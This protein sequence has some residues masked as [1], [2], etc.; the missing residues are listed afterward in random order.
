MT[1]GRGT[2]GG[3]NS[4]FRRRRV[5]HIVLVPGSRPP[6]RARRER[7][8][9]LFG[10]ELH[11]IKLGFENI[12]H[13][14]DRAG[15][16]QGEYPAVHV[17]GTNG[18][19]SVLAFLDA[20]LRAAGYRVGRYTSPHL[21]RLNERFLVDGGMI[22]DEALDEQIAFFKGIADGM[23]N[24]P[25]FFEMT[26]AIAFRHFAE[27]RVDLALVE[28]GLG[29][30]LDSTNVITPEVT[31]INTIGLEHTR[32]LGDTLEQ[33]AYEKAG[34]LKPGVPAVVGAIEEGPRAVILDRARELGVPIRLHGRDFQCQSEGLPWDQIFSFRAPGLTLDNVPLGLAG[35]HQAHNAGIA[36]ALALCLRGRFPGLGAEAI[37]S[38]LAHA[39]WPCRLERVLDE[40]PVIIDVAHN[41]AGARLL[42]E[43]IGRAVVVVAI[44]S[45]KDA[46]GILD[47]LA[48]LAQRTGSDEPAL[49]L[50][51]FGGSRALPLGALIR[52][53]G[54][55]PHQCLPDL[56]EALE[57]GMA[58]ATGECPL[59]VTG[60]IFFAGAARQVLMERFDAPP[61]VF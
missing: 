34:I 47:C 35:R 54:D 60:S 5:R 19:G 21:I 26:T 14:L 22:S 20:M 16:P 49:I 18:K 11:G 39:R 56:E 4:W 55:W 23:P 38:G 2:D 48:P 6:R 40:P 30:R 3:C 29:G 44:S 46:R 7:L 43:T 25:T 36:T 50:T 51:E 9:Y 27:A 10:L 24:P 31:A 32:F 45:D 8:S 42:A 41:V 15:N 59:L 1:V 33:I 28:V 57:R 13:F 58:L 61:P 52:A 37:A 17:A 53:A 12:R